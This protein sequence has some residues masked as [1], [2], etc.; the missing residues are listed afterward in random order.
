MKSAYEIA[1]EKLRQQDA[2]RSETRPVLTARQKEEI[3][4]IRQRGQARLAEREILYKAD[5]RKAASTKDPEAV[6]A[7]EESYRKDRARIEDDMEAKVKAVR[8]RGV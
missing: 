6:R 4:E 1:M 8:L 2:E 5:Q 7:V 3:A